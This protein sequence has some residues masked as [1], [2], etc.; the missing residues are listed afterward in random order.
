[1]SSADAG[2]GQLSGAIT[3]DDRPL[4]DQEV[5]LV[6]RL[7]SDPFSFPLAF[8]TWLVG[9]LET[10]DMTLPISAVIGLTSLLGVSGAGKG[11]LGILPAGI[12]LPF[13]GGTAP[14]G[15]KL[16]DGTGYSTTAEGRLFTAIGYTFGGGGS[17]F[18]VPDMQERIP[19]GKGVIPDHDTIGKHEGLPVGQ[20]RVRHKHTRLGWHNTGAASGTDV[21]VI[22]IGDATADSPEEL[23]HDHAPLDGL[24]APTD[25][26]AFLTLNFI[27]VA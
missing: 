24:P 26:P 5:A 17:V 1:M 14:P 3:A 6:Q 23:V 20:R 25:G 21:N 16:C 2:V 19:V 18:N 27:I 13:G 15:S 12:I 8:K 4:T 10:S 7:L 11:S 22:P 9:Y